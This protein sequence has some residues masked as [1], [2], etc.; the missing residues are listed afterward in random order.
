M[1]FSLFAYWFQPGLISHL[2]IFFSHNKPAPAGLDLSAQ[3]PRS[4][5]VVCHKLVA[6]TSTSG[7][8]AMREPDAHHRSP[9][10]DGYDN[11]IRKVP[12]PRTEARNSIR[13]Q[14]SSSIH[15]HTTLALTVTVTH[16]HHTR[17]QVDL[18]RTCCCVSSSISAPFHNHKRRKILLK[19]GMPPMSIIG[20]QLHTHTLPPST[21]QNNN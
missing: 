4:K 19:D 7:C 20:F 6:V 21:K 13:K 17:S 10:S 15:P 2:K 9:E 1:T 16:P 18:L 12:G 14:L 11:R 5:Q 8:D 3:K